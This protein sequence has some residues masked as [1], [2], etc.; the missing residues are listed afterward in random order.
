MNAVAE[1]TTPAPG[2]MSWAGFKAMAVESGQWIWGTAQGAFNTKATVSQIIVDAI[3]GMVPLLG[4]ATAVRDLI[5]VS[6]GLIDEPKKRDDKWE[7]VLLVVLL[8]ALIPVLGGVAKGVG[9]LIVD[10]AR[11]SA[12]TE[13]LAKDIVEVLNRIG[14]G[15][16]E[17]WLLKL[18]FAD[19]QAKIADALNRFTGAMIDGITAIRKR[20]SMPPSMANRLDRLKSGMAWLKG[21]GAKRIPDAI[22]ELDQKLREIQAYIRSGGETTSRVARYEVAA[23][24]KA[25]TYTDERRLL[26]DGPLPK[27]SVRGGWEQNP[28]DASDP[29]A[30]ASYYTPK[31]EEG[32]PNLAQIN[33][34]TVDDEGRIKAIAANSGRMT[35]RRLAKNEMI[36]RAFGPEGTTRGVPVGPTWP[37]GRW[38]WVGDPPANAE[39][40]RVNGAI[41][42][43]WNRNGYIVI[44]QIV[45]DEGPKVVTGTIAEQT[46]KELADQYFQGGASQAYFEVN[47]ASAKK[48]R[49]IGNEVMR[50]EKPQS[51][52]DPVSG[53]S[54]EVKPTGWENVNGVYGYSKIAGEGRVQTQK[55]QP[56]EQSGKVPERNP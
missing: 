39:I 20:I 31:P 46:G 34:H 56:R 52:I 50:T 36:S 4:D 6:I 49:E 12:K 33:E 38:W 8:L 26:E 3:I 23:G 53:I 37:D 30:W 10:A 17:Q 5:A 22:K 13:K 35:N 45:S 2:G 19:Y 41:L 1:D 18:R 43:E 15:N 11:T 42:D 55:L 24:E 14:H 40:W 9:R 28:A 51:W 32:Y 16:A 47:E 27:R 7:W 44:G 29:K 54:F 48:L 25:H 21:E